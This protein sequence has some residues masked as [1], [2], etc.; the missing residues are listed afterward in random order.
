MGTRGIP[1]R[2][3]DAQVNQAEWDAFYE[4]FGHARDRRTVAFFSRV[5][6]EPRCEAC[7]SPFAGQVGG[8]GGTSDFTAIGDV[9]RARVL[10]VR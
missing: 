5:P 7:G 9:V 2:P 4:R 8:E 10:A 1:D 6:S 3:V